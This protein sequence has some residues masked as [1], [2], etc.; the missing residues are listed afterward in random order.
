MEPKPIFDQEAAN[1]L[2]LCTLSQPE[3]SR[4]DYL[5]QQRKAHHLKREA[6]LR[7]MKQAAKHWQQKID[8]ANAKTKSKMLKPTELEGTS[9]PL[10]FYGFEGHLDRQAIEAVKLC[11]YLMEL[12]NLKKQAAEAL[13]QLKA[14]E[15]PNPNPEI[16]KDN[17][18]RQLFFYLM[19]EVQKTDGVK[20]SVIY[21]Y[22]KYE[23]LFSVA[24]KQEVYL[25]FC[26][27]RFGI[28]KP[29]RILPK[30]P[31]HE[32]YL[33]QDLPRLAQNFNAVT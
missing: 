1:E 13:E 5:N 3:E 27:D 18:A 8:Q 4:L 22:F 21:H 30:T 20:V 15:L 28:K 31:A 25:S 16:F 14:K 12:K 17:D 29:S 23:G 7:Y 10:L 2:L 26:A 19:E 33:K 9:I 11:L 6:F 24:N 32:D